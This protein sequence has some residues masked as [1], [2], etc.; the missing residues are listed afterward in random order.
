MP[1]LNGKP[2][3]QNTPITLFYSNQQC[4][5]GQWSIIWNIEKYQNI[6][7]ILD[8]NEKYI[9]L[10]DKL[11]SGE[12]KK[13]SL[14]QWDKLEI[15]PPNDNYYLQLT[16]K[17]EGKNVDIQHSNTALSLA[18]IQP[19][20]E[21]FENFHRP[22]F[23]RPSALQSRLNQEFKLVGIVD[24]QPHDDE[25]LMSPYLK[26]LDDL[27]ARNGIVYVVEHTVE[28][29]PLMMNVGMSSL[30]ITYWHKENPN[31]TPPN[32]DKTMKILEPDDKS[33]FTAQ[34]PNNKCT[35]HNKL[36]LSCTSFSS[37]AS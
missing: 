32:Y 22:K 14:R 19:T 5:Q 16:T 31:D 8:R 9:V 13:R 21:D 2:K 28:V 36:A 17:T 20:V 26:E 1:N 4:A 6:P 33:P 29:P 15:L 11:D 37:C 24:T 34:I 25:H 7:L 10:S 35:S 27:S 12:R 23:L 30:L 18:L 3:P